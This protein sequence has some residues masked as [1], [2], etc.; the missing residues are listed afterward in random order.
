MIRIAR[1]WGFV[2]IGVFF[3]R[4]F[5][6]GTLNVL[7]EK[8]VHPISMG[9]VCWRMRMCLRCHPGGDP[10]ACWCINISITC[11]NA[12]SRHRNTNIVIYVEQTNDKQ[13]HGNHCNKNSAFLV[14]NSHYISAF[15]GHNAAPCIIMTEASPSTNASALPDAI[16]PPAE[17]DYHIQSV[18]PQHL[19]D[20]GSAGWLRS[21]ETVLKLLQQAHIEMSTDQEE[22]V[23]D[24]IIQHDKL[25]VLVHEIYT[26]LIWRT[27]VLPRLLAIEAQPTATLASAIVF[28]S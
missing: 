27:K 25:P 22:I 18:Q 5:L 21:H 20:I 23:A 1:R 11:I 4:C 8:C 17:L 6:I 15:S 10:L 7:K 28:C 12:T 19:A 3:V 24:L 13:N 9:S 2:G 16:I 26:V 14:V